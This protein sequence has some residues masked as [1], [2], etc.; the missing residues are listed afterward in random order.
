MNQK[1]E[2]FRM[3]RLQQITRSYLLLLNI[4]FQMAYGQ[5]IQESN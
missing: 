5:F 2:H 4:L 3:G 1:L